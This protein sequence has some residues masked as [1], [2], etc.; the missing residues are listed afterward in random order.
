MENKFIQIAG[1]GRT[2]AM[3][4]L[5]TFFLVVGMFFLGQFPFTFL[6]L[7]AGQRTVDYSPEIAAR[8][9]FAV[10]FLL[11]M[12]QFITG[13]AGLWL[14]VKYI[15]Q[16]PFV[17]VISA[18]RKF[19]TGNFLYGIFI[20]LLVVGGTDLVHYLIDPSEFIWQFNASAFFP[21]L[22]VAILVFP[23]QVGFEELVFRGY[24]MPSAGYHSRSAWVG[25][26]VSSVTFG[27]LH[28]FNNEVSEF[29]ALRMMAIYISLGLVLGLTTLVSEGVEIAWGIHLVNNLYVALV[30][31]F[32]GS[33]LQTPALFT[34]PPPDIRTMVIESVVLCVVL[35]FFV[36]LRFRKKSLSKLF[37]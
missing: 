3:T 15:H 4:Y 12:F 2:N 26:L 16:R 11:L 21:F 34:T 5:A 18:E 19:R 32:P 33:S 24:M 30:K 31:T 17:T 20:T 36:W 13:L 6:I 10:Y 7:A 9:P 8:V 22:L 35:L 29:G 25:L 23:L 1:E 27:L 37:A 28:I 14:C